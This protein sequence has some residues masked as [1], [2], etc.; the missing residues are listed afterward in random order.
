METSVIRLTNLSGTTFVIDVSALALVSNLSVKDFVVTHNGLDVTTSYTKTSAT[1]V[2]YSGSNVVLGTRVELYRST[3]L[4]FGETTF[5][6]TTTTVEMTNALS[7]LKRRVDELEARTAWQSALI[8]QGGLTLGT[9]PILDNVYDASAWNGD[10]SN[11]PSRNTIRDHLEKQTKLAIQSSFGNENIPALDAF[12][13]RSV[14]IEYQ[15]SNL[16][17]YDNATKRFNVI[18][19]GNYL[20]CYIATLQATGGTP[21]T[22][23]DSIISLGINGGNDTI[24]LARHTFNVASSSP[25]VSLASQAVVGLSAGSY[26]TA[27]ALYNGIGGGG[28]GVSTDRTRFSITKLRT[29]D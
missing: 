3:G 18:A 8:T 25:S 7:K 11:A 1:Q 4:T 5:L 21:P 24:R 9:V 14:T 6:S 2:T 28:Y 22:I 10:T 16:I 23:V 12:Q 15:N 26:I 20:V 17:Q 19:D 27:Q 29:S 13:N